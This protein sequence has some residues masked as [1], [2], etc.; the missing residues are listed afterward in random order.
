MRDKTILNYSWER[1]IEFFDAPDSL[2]YLDLLIKKKYYSS[3]NFIENDL[4]TMAKL[5][6]YAQGKFVLNLNDCDKV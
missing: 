6:E 2:F 3:K 1:V 4:V 5:F